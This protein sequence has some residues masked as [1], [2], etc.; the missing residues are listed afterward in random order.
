MCLQLCEKGIVPCAASAIVA[1]IE[2][3]Y[4]SSLSS[5][6]RFYRPLGPLLVLLTVRS[7][8]LLHSWVDCCVWC[9]CARTHGLLYRLVPVRTLDYAC[10]VML[11]GGGP[12]RPV[13]AVTAQRR[14][15]GR[16]DVGACR[17]EPY[18]PTVF[19]TGRQKD[20]RFPR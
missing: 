6:F 13:A 1:T 3:K 8:P 20:V 9:P 10:R 7:P 11:R 12:E 17:R 18:G 4:P 5:S 14:V 16:H 19:R 2:E 15:A